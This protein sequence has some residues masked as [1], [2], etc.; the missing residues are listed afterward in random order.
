VLQ[1]RSLKNPEWYISPSLDPIFEM[2]ELYD[3]VLH[4]YLSMDDC[5][6]IVATGLSQCAYDRVKFYYRLRD[7]ESFLRMIGLQCFSVLPRMT[8]D[9]LIQFSTNS[10]AIA[11]REKLLAIYIIGI[12]EKLFSEI[13]VRENNLFVSLTYP[14]EV[15]KETKIRCGMQEYELKPLVSF[16]AI[17]NGMH[18]EKGFAF[19][20]DNLES[21]APQDNM[22]VKEINTTIKDY[23]K[24]K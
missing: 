15:F 11:A 16:V 1:E 21:L 2:L 19:F 10:E 24:G 18:Q 6:L 3:H 8:R 12:N 13:D 4:D 20:S 22:H 9:F 17:K 14:N 5:E 7:H 23:F